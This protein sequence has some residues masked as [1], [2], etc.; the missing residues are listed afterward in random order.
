MRQFLFVIFFLM[1]IGF[2]IAGDDPYVSRFEG[3]I[4]YSHM[5]LRLDADSKQP[6]GIAIGLTYHLKNRIAIHGQLDG[7]EFGPYACIGSGTVECGE[8][9]TA[10]IGP[11]IN[12]LL[13][14]HWIPFAE[15]LLGATRSKVNQF[16][17]PPVGTDPY[18]V[19]HIK[20]TRHAGFASSF[21]VGVNLRYKRVVI[22]LSQLDCINYSN[23]NNRHLSM[24]FSA[25]IGMGFG[26]KL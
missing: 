1:P 13:R 17:W 3:T 6:N 14:S 24:R 7:Y 9:A 10:M 26:K 2:G 23:G 11:R 18:E 8:A 16:Y 4:E 25:G 5:P 22:K 21:G 15:V 12:L 20:E 19:E